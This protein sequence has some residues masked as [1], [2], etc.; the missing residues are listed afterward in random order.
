MYLTENTLKAKNIK[1]FQTNTYKV[2][3]SIEIMI[4]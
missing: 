2:Y 4:L 1:T 3:L